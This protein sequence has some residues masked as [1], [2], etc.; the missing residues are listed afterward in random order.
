M[1][2]VN[3]DALISIF[4]TVNF[5]E[6]GLFLAMGT[7]IG[8]S[9]GAI[10]GLSPALAIALALPIVLWLPIHEGLAL[11]VGT[12]KGGTFGGSITAICFATPGTSASAA[13]VAD[14][15]ALT[16][17]NQ[18]G[19]ALKTS[20]YASVVGDSTS[21]LALI[22]IAIPLGALA[23]LLGPPQL[24]ALF[25]LALTIIIIFSADDPARGIISAGT[26][27]L[28]GA[29]GRDVHT[30]VI[31]LDFGLYGLHSGVSLVAL[32]LGLFSIPEL[33]FQLNKLWKQR[34]QDYKEPTLDAQEGMKQKLTLREF[35]ATWRGLVVGTTTGTLVGALP[36]PGATLAAFVGYGLTRQFSRKPEEYGKGSL[37]GIAAA[38]SANNATCGATLIPLLTFGIPGSLIAGLFGAALMM[39]GIPPGPRVIVD[40]PETI[41][42]L[43][44]IFLLGNPIALVLGR[45]LIPVFTRLAYVPAIVMWPIIGV[46]VVTGTYGFEIREFDVLILLF[47]GALGFAFR[48][49]RIP[50]GPL[51]LAFLVGPLFEESLRRSLTIARGNYFYFIESPVSLGLWI[52]CAAAIALFLYGRIRMR[53]R[54]IKE[55]Q[56]LD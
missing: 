55:E 7:A 18:G 4:T 31:R 30:G 6:L 16:R 21:D 28:L 53:R 35:L 17:K 38:E 41:Y 2:E 20:L 46:F 32:L 27:F 49:M 10:P 3:V 42:L 24:T 15:Y 52:A 50:F 45:I 44:L 54:G 14:G 43:F 39:K 12:Y 36:G 13:T 48:L 1:F 25:F 26:G 34:R 40:Y 19:K 51:V 22:F 9:V 5:F 8:I 29:V 33:I 37:E 11:L 47:A 23:P 56:I